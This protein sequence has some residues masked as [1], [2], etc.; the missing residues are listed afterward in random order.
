MSDENA[1]GYGPDY[2]MVL[3]TDGSEKNDRPVAGWGLHGYV[4]P[5]VDEKK[6]KFTKKKDAHSTIGYIDGRTFTK[7]YPTGSRAFDIDPGPQP[8]KK[9]LEKKE[10]P[11]TPELFFDFSGGLPNGTVS[12]AEMRAMERALDLVIEYAPAQCMIRAD[13]EYVLKTIFNWYWGWEKNGWHKSDGSVPS[14]LDAWHAIMG[15]FKRIL[16]TDTVLRIIHVRAHQGEPGNEIA[17][18]LAYMGGNLGRLKEPDVE[19]ISDAKGY[20]QKEKLSSRFMDQRW[21]YDL[22][23][24]DPT[25]YTNDGRSVYFFGNHGKAESED[26]LVG[27]FTPNG[28]IG[29]LVRSEPEPVLDML[30]SVLHKSY[31]DG[32]TR[33]VLGYLENILNTERYAE[34]AD[35]GE[36]SVYPYAHRP[37]V[38]SADRVPLIKELSPPYFGFRLIE[39]MTEMLRDVI[40]AEKMINGESSTNRRLAVTNITNQIFFK[41]VNAKGKVTFKTCDEIN[42]PAITLSVNA[43]YNTGDEIKTHKLKLK[44]GQDI[45]VRN[46]LAA[47]MGEDTEVYVITMKLSSDAF[48]FGTL[49]KDNE[50]LL[51]S[52]AMK[53]NKIVLMGGK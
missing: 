45:P 32:T 47:V 36:R 29:I 26:D 27:K 12:T 44:L 46:T 6:V 17:D 14:H 51:F 7:E 33:V 4:Y 38:M 42:S 9:L 24:S 8:D 11:V 3:Y 48:I 40:E 52:S 43:D 15:K 23:D 2:G 1:V 19:R 16:Q 53:S 28:K 37:M 35:V 20:K 21:W 5:M 13:S 41:E 30:H 25:E 10:M 49:I 18:T 50:N 31:F 34:L 39:T 22:I